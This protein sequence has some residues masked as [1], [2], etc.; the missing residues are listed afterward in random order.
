MRAGGE[1]PTGGG[2]R[3]GA[4]GRRRPATTHRAEVTERPRHTLTQ[5]GRRIARV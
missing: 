3:R 1:G 4:G 5:A 2:L